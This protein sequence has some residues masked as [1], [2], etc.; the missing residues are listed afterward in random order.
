[1]NLNATV[2][3]KSDQLN[4]D[5]LIAGP[6][7]IRITSVESGSAEQPVVIQYEGGK[8][9]PYKPSKSMRRV[10]IVLWGA[11]GNAYVGRSITLYRDPAVEYGGDPVGGIKISHASDIAE[12]QTIMLTVRRGKRKPHRVD[13]LVEESAPSGNASE[14]PA[15]PMD[16]LVAAGDIMSAQGL[17]IYQNWFT[18]NLT[19]KERQ[20]LAEHH[21]KWKQLA[22]GR[23]AA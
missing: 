21:A 19:K 4:A 18:T 8:G 7:T 16:E 5:D 1:M 11:E 3:P 15:R 17:A 13:P 22:E 12:G 14:K 6:R 23:T 10:L 20:L 2:V 9:R